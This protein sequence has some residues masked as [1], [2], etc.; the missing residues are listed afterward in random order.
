MNIKTVQGLASLNA[1]VTRQAATLAYLQDFRFMM[2]LVLCAL[3]LLFLL[4]AVVAKTNND[5]SGKLPEF[6]L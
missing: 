3:P 5:L 2:W 4:K 6:E 1:E